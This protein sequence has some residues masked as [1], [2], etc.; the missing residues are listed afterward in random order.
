MFC[1]KGKHSG[2]GGGKI[3][4][5]IGMERYSLFVFLFFLVSC[6][7]T[8]NLR[9]GYVAK[10]TVAQKLVAILPAFVNIHVKERD[11]A[12]ISQEAIN[13]G[14]LK[15]GFIIQTELYNRMQKNK[16]I[17]NVQPIKL[18]NDKLFAGGLSF[19]KYKTM[20]ET[21]LAKILQVDAVIFMKTDLS[22]MG[23]KSIDVFV[24]LGSRN[25]FL[26]GASLTAISA[27]TAKEVQ[28]DKITLKVGIVESNSGAEIW[29]RV[30][31]NEPPNYDELEY[32]FSKSLYRVSKIIPYRK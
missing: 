28:T 8:K 9:N 19:S 2:S 27:A 13:E 29:Q 17:V 26:L 6:S 21:E 18:T 7:S 24:G 14:E 25:I 15:L 11:S 10:E 4:K 30:Y 31:I 22:K 32:F 3:D 16:Y 5:I 12:K 1:K 20:N 23:Y